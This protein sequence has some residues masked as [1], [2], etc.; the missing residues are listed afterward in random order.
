MTTQEMNAAFDNLVNSFGKPSV[1]D[2]IKSVSGPD[3]KIEV[4]KRNVGFYVRVETVGGIGQSSV[5]R[6]VK[7]DNDASVIDAIL[8]L[9][10]KIRK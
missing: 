8:E 3:I 1:A 7:D 2:V 5:C 4:T 9:T 10:E 6:I